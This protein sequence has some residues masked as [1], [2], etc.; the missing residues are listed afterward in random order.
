MRW[1][2]FVRLNVNPRAAMA[3]RVVFGPLRMFHAFLKTDIYIVRIS[4]QHMGLG[5][6][7]RLACFL[8]LQSRRQSAVDEEIVRI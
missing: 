4:L 3:P 1:H 7:F 5:L 2:T 8:C 6:W